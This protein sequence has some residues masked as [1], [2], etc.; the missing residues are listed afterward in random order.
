MSKVMKARINWLPPEHGGRQRPPIGVR[1]VTVS[2][3]DQDDEQWRK[4]AWS[5]VLEKNEPSKNPLE[6][7]AD[8]HFLAPDAPDELLYKGAVF[9]LYEGRRRVAMGEVL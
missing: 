3:F 9:E 2:R 4:E 7:V 1:Y 8:I 6:T 5:L